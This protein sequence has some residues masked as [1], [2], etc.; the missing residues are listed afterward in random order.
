MGLLWAVEGFAG[1]GASLVCCSADG[2]RAA[3]SPAAV[4]GRGLLA[5]LILRLRVEKS[6]GL[7]V[8]AI[9]GAP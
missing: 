9:G 8:A 7:A 5:A 2:S 6:L 4:A 3:P 1:C